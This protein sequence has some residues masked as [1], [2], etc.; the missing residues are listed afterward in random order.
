MKSFV[1][2]IIVF[3]LLLLALNMAGY[4]IVYKRYLSD[5]EEVKLNYKSYI[6]GDSQGKAVGDLGEEIG[7]YNFSDDSDSYEDIYRKTT[8][9]LLNTQID[10]LFISVNDH[11]LSSYRDKRNNSD[12]SLVFEEKSFLGGVKYFLINRYLVL[13]NSKYRD[14]IKL[15]LKSEESDKKELEWNDYTEDEKKFYARRR[16]KGQFVG[17]TQSARMKKYL[18]RIIKACKENNVVLIGVKFP[19]THQL[20]TLIINKSFF[21]DEVLRGE[22]CEVF[23]FSKKLYQNPNMFKDTDH[24][25]ALGAKRFWELFYKELNRGNSF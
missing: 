16:E 11:T 14:I 23:D 12:R 20:N 7:V 3:S 17:K 18:R 10:T 8:F 1:K 24:L 19:I 5:Y 13:T 22:K 2:N 6:L 21:A 4:Q 25:N 9:L 15:S